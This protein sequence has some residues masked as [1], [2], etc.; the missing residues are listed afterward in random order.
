[1]KIEQKELKEIGRFIQDICTKTSSGN[2]EAVSADGGAAVGDAL[3]TMVFDQLEYKGT[4]WHNVKKV[5]VTRGP[6]VKLRSRV[7]SLAFEPSY[8]IRSY[9]IAEGDQSTASNVKYQT[10]TA[11]LGKL[12][13][14]VPITEELAWDVTEIGQMVLEDATESQIYK[15]EHEM[16]YGTA[17]IVGVM[18][19]TSCVATLASNCA[20][21][22]PTQANLAAAV[23]KLHPMAMN[24][25]WYFSKAVYSSILKI[26]FTTPNALAFEN[27][28]YWL[29]GFPVNVLPQL[30]AAPYQWLLGDFT[31]YSIGYIKPKF[32]TADGIR[33]LE[34]ERELRLSQRIAGDVYVARTSDDDAGTTYGWF[35]IPDTPA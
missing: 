3:S 35:I 16:L 30:T 2:N 6:T 14:R 8:G 20:A 28:K 32:D 29:F 10:T 19:A 22:V 26:A 9:W 1:M 18:N 31:R 33:F 25:E 21:T 24:A 12:V 13:T 17:S 11:A 27:G 5:E 7:N 23:D 34:G 4:F 15:I